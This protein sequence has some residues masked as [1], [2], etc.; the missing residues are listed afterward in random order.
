MTCSNPNLPLPHV[1]DPCFHDPFPSLALVQPEYL[2]LFS[3]WLL[4]TN[5]PLVTGG[6]A[7]RMPRKLGQLTVA[8][9]IYQCSSRLGLDSRRLQ[10]RPAWT[11]PQSRGGPHQST[12]LS[13]RKQMG[14]LCAPEA[15]VAVAQCYCNLLEMCSD[16]E[17]RMGAY[18]QDK[19]L[20]HLE[21]RWR[22]SQARGEELPE[23]RQL[24]SE[25]TS[26]RLPLRSSL[27]LRQWFSTCPML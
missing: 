16:P 10:G 15:R 11:C 3:P 8:D 23:E 27:H 20:G 19:L 25:E 13:A 2:P 26:K 18:T 6:E 1:L 12:D 22:S 9:D 17:T 21:R 4:L 24:P 7:L 5:V 14:S